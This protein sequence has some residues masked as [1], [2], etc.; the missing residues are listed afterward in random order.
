MDEKWKDSSLPIP[1][2]V[3]AL[4]ERMDIREKL[5]ILVETSQANERLG[6]PLY[7]HGNE[8]LHGMVRPG[9]STV[10]P[11]AIAFGATFDEELIE[12]IADAISDE[13]RARYF[14]GRGVDV[15]E[16]E[17]DARY[18]GLLTFWSPDL[19]LARDPRWGRTGETYGEDPYLAGKLGAAFVRGLQ[20]KD[21]DHLKAVATP[22]HFTANNEEHNRFSCNAKMSEKTLREY[23]LR[24]FEIAVKEGH[25]EAIMGAYNAINGIPCHM[26]PRLLIDILRKEWGF[27][28]YVVSDCS[29]IARIWDQHKIFEE[30]KDAAS[31]ALNGGVDLECGSYS[32]YEHF[33]LTFLEEQL[34][35][36]KVTEERIDE[37]CRRVLTARFKLGQ[38]DPPE[39]S[40]YYNIP[41]SVIGSKEHCDLAY[42]AAAES[43]VLL[44]NDGILPLKSSA[45]V[46]LV[47]N[48]ADLCQFGDYSG[49][50][51]NPPISPLEGILAVGGD[52][53]SFARWSFSRADQDF[54]VIDSS[55]LLSEDRTPGLSAYYYDNSAFL[56][57]A[58]V[59]TD[60][61][62]DFAWRDSMPD[63]FIETSQYSIRW[64]GFLCPSVSGL[65]RLRLV[66]TGN[67]PCDVPRLILGGEEKGTSAAVALRAGEPV[68]LCVEY[69]KSEEEPR[70]RL[71]WTVPQNSDDPYAEECRIA[72]EAEAVIA[73]VG[74]GTEYEREGRDKDT[75]ELPEEQ[76]RLLKRLYEVNR[77]LIVVL[78]NGSPVSIPWIEKHA[79][80][81][82][83]AWYPG[84]RGGEALADILYGKVSP[85]GKL[86][87]SFPRSVEDIP[88]FDD[89][90]NVHGRTYMYARREP[91]YPFGFG[92]SYTKFRYDALSLTVSGDKAYYSFSVTNVGAMDGREV[93]LVTADSAG[94]R[95][96]PV[97]R[98]VR[99][100]S[101]DL[102]KGE[103]RNV[104]VTLSKEDL[105]LVNEEGQRVLL[106][107][108]YTVCAGGSL[109]DNRRRQ[110]GSS[111]C[112]RVF[113]CVTGD[114]LLQKADR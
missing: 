92:L 99:F 20:G 8:A 59:R 18:S 39:E 24:P 91:L 34:A 31:A 80:A 25:P 113:L 63:S 66:H 44:K 61:E 76:L 58:K 107:G 6:I 22:K 30:P 82:L 32:P 42:R 37:A 7:F 83:E 96:Q 101:L 5:M 15:S 97:C 110:L 11:Q 56:G 19:N 78:I 60:R 17:Y 51:L 62:I 104:T 65:Y 95:N 9:K 102:K 53:V 81:V 16:E 28:G 13:T 50:P 98:L 4:M 40:P 79:A 26:N 14:H 36:G 67:A 68:S 10:F 86:C 27:D 106:P 93:V 45:K 29:A 70:I 12:Q 103:K 73:V 114:G 57:K 87:V 74:L 48:N 112:D 71:E 49:V 105:S 94:H 2:R 100:V 75:L 55:F 111:L 33:Y 108:R 72:S 85:S 84:E 1:E 77:K 54:T 52:N 41:L 47:G 43:M 88:A 21:P 89:Y 35:A 90:E 109:P 38:F 3:S 23:H 69:A 46:A 64:K